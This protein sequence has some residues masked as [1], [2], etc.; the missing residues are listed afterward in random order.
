LKRIFARPSRTT[1]PS[2]DADAVASYL[3]ASE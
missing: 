2:K 3:D 1:G